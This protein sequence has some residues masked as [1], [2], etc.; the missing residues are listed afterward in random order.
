MKASFLVKLFVALAVLLGSSTYASADTIGAIS[1]T[2]ANSYNSTSFTFVGNP[3]VLAATTTGSFT[4]F[5]SAA[6][7]TA[8][9]FTFSPI[10]TPFQIFSITEGSNT[11]TIFFDSLD[12]IVNTPGALA[13]TGLATIDLNGVITDGTFSLSSQ[14]GDKTPVVSFSATAL[15]PTPEP[16]T[17]FLLGTGLVGSAGAFFRR[18]RTLTA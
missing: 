12:T 18:R 14:F 15:A 8:N 1:F 2:G 4:I 5:D 7:V 11:L 16:S 17:L 6:A 9:S 3:T 13:L 10:F